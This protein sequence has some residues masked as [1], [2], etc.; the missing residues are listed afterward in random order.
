MVAPGVINNH[1]WARLRLE[2]G[3]ANMKSAIHHFTGG[4]VGGLMNI[5]GAAVL[6]ASLNQAA[7]QKFLAFP[8]SKPTQEMLS[9]WT[10][11]L[12]IPWSLA[13]PQI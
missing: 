5:S 11:P 3:A 13:L 1:H 10:S 12:S 7:A 6:K 2:K 9:K 4:D 8:F